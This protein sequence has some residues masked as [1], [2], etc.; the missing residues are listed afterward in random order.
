MYIYCESWY[1][2]NFIA[3][4]GFQSM[5]DARL[6]LEQKQDKIEVKKETVTHSP[7]ASVSSS[8]IFSLKMLSLKALLAQ[9][10]KLGKDYISRQLPSQLHDD[11]VHF[12]QENL[13]HL[14]DAILR[15]DPIAAQKMIKEYPILLLEKLEEK[16]FVTACSGQKSA[17]KTPYQ[18][19]LAEEDTQMAAMLKA[20]LI[21]VADAKEADAQFNEQFPKGWEVDEQKRWQ[22]IFGQ[23][24]TLTQ[25]IRHAAPGDIT[26][27]GHPEYKLTVRK[28]SKVAIELAQFRSLLDAT[29]NE[30]VTTGRHFNP[31]LLQRAFQIYD[32]HYHDYF[33]NDWSDPRAML[34]WQ[35]TIGY[36]E[37]LFPANYVQAACDGFYNTEEKLR[38]GTPQARS[39]K[40]EVYHS[41][42]GAWAPADF[43]PLSSSR[44]GFDFAIFA[45]GAA[46]GGCGQGVAGLSAG[47]RTACDALRPFR[48][49]C[50][51]KTASLQNL[52]RTQTIAAERRCLVQ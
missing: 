5:A 26:S 33:G 17:K 47:M 32:D 45:R 12:K 37:R 6:H 43:Y 7:S 48:S 29:L 2:L 24:D 36:I 34:F 8:G 38:S 4:M 16:D 23:L 40:F 13:K 9:E 30:I 50:Q 19:A 14:L 39:F 25:A 11:Y 44:L 3:C 42:R 52:C 46:A 35:Q 15:G 10:H 49:L 51:S 20:Q 1:N 18:M 27:S 41:G 28:G 21:F 22:P 31:D